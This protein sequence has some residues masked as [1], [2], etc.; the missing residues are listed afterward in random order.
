MFVNSDDI[1]KMDQ[2]Y[3][4]A[5]I[6]SITGFKSANLVGTVDANGI[7][8]LNIV[9]SCVHIGAHPPLIG[10]ISRPHSVPRDTIEN[11]EATGFYTINHI[12]EAI[13]RQAH[14]TSARYPQDQSEFDA[15]GL[16]E[17]WE[18]DFTAPYVQESL[19]RMGIKFRKKLPIDINNTDM[20]IG[21]IIQIHIPEDCLVENGSVDIEKAGSI[22]I[23]GL[24]RYH[25]TQHIARLSYAKPDQKIKV[26]E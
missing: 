3:R 16:T 10:F 17:L 2:R 9:N 1:E 15:T 7:T 14:Q 13:F 26:I 21:E 25:R 22:A 11:I 8:N 23:S 5:L 18:N 24:D 6:N 19:L 12:N 20:I 4:I